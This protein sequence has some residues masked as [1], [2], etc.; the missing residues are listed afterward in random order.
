MIQ[1]AMGVLVNS[2]GQLVDN[3]YGRGSYTNNLIYHRYFDRLDSHNYITGG[4][5]LV[6]GT[7][8]IIPDVPL[9]KAW[10]GIYFTMLI[11]TMQ[12]EVYGSPYI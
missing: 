1:R 11:E 8:G 10:W 2:C 3:D 12:G 4:S 7:N 6:Y 9:H 5:P